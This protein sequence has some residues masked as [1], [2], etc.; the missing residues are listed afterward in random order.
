[1]RFEPTKGVKIQAFAIW[2][3]YAKCMSLCECNQYVY[4]C[5]SVMMMMMM[6]VCVCVHISYWIPVYM[7]LSMCEHLLSIWLCLSVCE[8]MHVS[9]CI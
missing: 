4:T 2:Q 9:P 1:M 5:V 8:C 3:H 7:S 6:Y